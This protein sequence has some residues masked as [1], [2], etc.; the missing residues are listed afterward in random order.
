MG[1]MALDLMTDAKIKDNPDEEHSNQKS[2]D[3]CLHR[4]RKR[5]CEKAMQTTQKSQ[6]RAQSTAVS[7]MDTRVQARCK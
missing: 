7:P 1:C 3:P 6:E 5:N 2:Q 4:S